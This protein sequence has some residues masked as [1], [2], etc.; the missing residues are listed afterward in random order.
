MRIV[1]L[2]LTLSL[3]ITIMAAGSI[4][5]DGD[6]DSET[7][8]SGTT[9]PGELPTLYKGDKWEYSAIDGDTEYD[10]VLT[11]TDVGTYYTMEMK[12]D[13]PLMGSINK[14][15]AQFDK[16]LLLPVSMDMS[17][18]DEEAGME[19]DF[20]TNVSYELSGDRWPLVVGKEIEVTETTTTIMDFA[21]EET[22]DTD[23][24]TTTYKVEAM[25]TIT[26][27]AGTFECYRIAKY[28]ESGEKE[29]TSWHSDKVK[30]NIKEIDH[31]LGEV[32]ELTDYSI[33]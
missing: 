2:V 10:L 4:G 31:D 9:G 6:N 29:S 21:G 32:Q 19:F 24:T 23:S 14:A 22:T 26:V 18:K 27:E 30:T 20:N 1:T 15:T 11:V 25:E 13:P 8:G 7:D 12:M 17:G 33:K 3:L 5:C 28:D 16:E